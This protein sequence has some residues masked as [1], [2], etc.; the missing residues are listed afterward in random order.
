[1]RFIAALVLLL[2]ATAAAPS[3]RAA[4]EAALARAMAD[5]AV[6]AV[7][8]LEIRDGRV[9]GEAARGVRRMDRPGTVRVGDR[10]HLG[11]NTKA[12][13]A[14]LVARLVDQGKLSWTARLD[15]LLPE[16]AGT[17]RPE[18]RDVTLADL[19]S[20]RSGLPENVSDEAFFKSFYQDRRGL[21]EQ[22]LAYVA[23]ALTEA[24]AAEKRA[25]M[26]YSNTGYLLA[27]VIAERAARRPYERLMRDEVFRPLGMASAGFDY[28][29]AGPWGHVDGRVATA[30]DANPPMFNP[31]G[32]AQMTL[33]DWARFCI[34]QI[35]G[36]RGKGRL[37]RPDTYRFVQTGQGGTRSGLGW[38]VAPAALG[39][40]GPALTHSG[41]DGNWFAVVILYPGSRSGVLVAANAAESMGGDAAA[42]A[43]ARERAATLAPPAPAS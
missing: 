9:A 15:A 27:A 12:M 36:A 20:H 14:T 23:R 43:A 13:T 39:R 33:K 17:M 3:D 25:A 32:Q 42:I 18:Y 40:A 29:P 30:A 10:W 16:L 5:K 31:A 37:L 38:G 24:P 21:P 35:E 6:P 26:S 22:R 19:L 28:S 7:A 8:M 11:S 1:M 4:L 34:D 2:F 41:S